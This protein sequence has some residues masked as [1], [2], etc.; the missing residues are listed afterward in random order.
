M[1]KH[2]S[3][4]SAFPID[5]PPISVISN[6]FPVGVN[7]TFPPSRLQPPRRPEACDRGPVHIGH[8]ACVS[9]MAAVWR[10]R[11][12]APSAREWRARSTET[13]QDPT[14]AHDACA[15]IPRH[16]IDRAKGWP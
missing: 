13:E 8:R 15:E 2:V 16:S 14:Q 7:L 12:T 3:A 11:P 6:T 5:D 9:A 4:S 1:C 10:H